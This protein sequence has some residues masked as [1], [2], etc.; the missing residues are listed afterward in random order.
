MKKPATASASEA[1]SNDAGSSS[2]AFVAASAGT[3]A[4]SE[5]ITSTAD[6]VVQ[7]TGSSNLPVATM[8]DTPQTT[9]TG[10]SSSGSDLFPDMKTDLQPNL[11][12][13]IQPDLY[14]EL[15]PDLH[16]KLHTNHQ[17]DVHTD[18]QPDIHTGLHTNLDTDDTE[19]RN[20][21]EDSNCS[22]S[23]LQC[24]ETI[25]QIHPLPADLN[26]PI[27]VSSPVNLDVVLSQISG[28]KLIVLFCKISFCDQLY[29]TDDQLK[30]V[31]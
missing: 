25:Q 2:A 21:E 7:Q 10:D 23:L 15:Q 5:N 19:V 18:L 24:S 8:V 3:E 13:D 11:Q 9:D 22:V 4:A 27:S 6:P 12:T 20:S 16:T 17:P 30:N 26:E 1:G 28:T 29:Q 31:F 14:T